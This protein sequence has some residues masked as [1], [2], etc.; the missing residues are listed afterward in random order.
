MSAV[1]LSICIVS[2]SLQSV[3]KKKLN[4]K[5]EGCE[6]SVSMIISLFALI[7]FIVFSNGYIFDMRLI[8]YCI[9]FSVC[10]ATAAATCV[11][12]LACGSLALTNMVLAY[13][14]IIPL[15][16]SIF[17]LGEVLN[18]FQ[19]SGVILLGLSFLFTYYPGEKKK[20]ELKWMVYAILLFASNGMCGAVQKMQKEAF[21]G[22]FDSSFMIISLIMVMVLLLVLAIIREGKRILIA[23]KYGFIQCSL[24]GI[25]NGAANYFALLCLAVVPGSVYYPFNAAGGLV[26][27]YIFS[28]TIF[29]EKFNKN[30]IIG[31]IL[32]ILSMILINI[33]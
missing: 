3:F 33:K 4:K 15:G 9:A 24:S 11:L 10:Y 29:K 12:A 30:Q 32:G 26:L 19:I 2:A 18:I 5:C 7:Y 31:F 17:A 25:C 13:S 23:F 28:I 1:L 16:Y 14:C 8:P 27:T 22:A 20:I 6:F 21:G